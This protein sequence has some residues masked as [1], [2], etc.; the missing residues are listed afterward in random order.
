MTSFF[1]TLLA[2]LRAI[3]RGLRDPEFRTLFIVLLLMLTSG[4]IFYS[5]VEGWSAIDSIYFSVITLTT[6]GYGDLHPTEPISKIF[7]ILYICMGVGLIMTFINTLAKHNL[8]HG[9]HHKGTREA[10]KGKR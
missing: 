9:G 6:V 5:T 8:R 7:T 3:A 1:F 10:K 4:T 2:F